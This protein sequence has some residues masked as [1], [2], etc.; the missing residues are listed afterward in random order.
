ME[1]HQWLAA[2]I[3]HW[4][5]AVPRQV[6]RA[7]WWVLASTAG[8]LVGGLVSGISGGIVGL[9]MIGAV[10]G[11]ITGTVLIWLLG[12]PMSTASSAE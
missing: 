1:S 2:G 11:S 9:A 8:W 5:R 10:Y 4:F 6:A 7:G 3:S 12:Q